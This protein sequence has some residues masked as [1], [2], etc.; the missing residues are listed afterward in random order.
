[1]SFSRSHTSTSLLSLLRPHDITSVLA[2]SSP[3]A[4]VHPKHPRSTECMTLPLSSF[5]EAQSTVDILRVPHAILLSL[6]FNTTGPFH[7]GCM[8]QRWG[9]VDE[10][11]CESAFPNQP[12][13]VK[14]DSC[15]N[16][17]AQLVFPG[18]RHI[19]FCDCGLDSGNELLLSPT[20]TTAPTTLST[21]ACLQDMSQHRET[22]V[23]PSLGGC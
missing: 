12:K 13:L 20:K 3:I 17:M 16:R 22:P 8:H 11:I 10:H 19:R 23:E 2:C 6:V 7:T 15:I 1:M 4:H 9:E 21:N 18:K 14:H 5:H